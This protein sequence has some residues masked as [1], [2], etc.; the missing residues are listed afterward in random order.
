M[1]REDLN[2]IINAIE[3]VK[4]EINQNMNERFEEQDKG[5]DEKFKEQ[6]KRINEM[7]KKQEQK[8]A[9][10]FKDQD[11]KNQQK[12]DKQNDRISSLESKFEDFKVIVR[13]EI[14]NTI[15]DQMFIFEERY[16]RALTLAV[17][18]MNHK[19]SNEEAQNIRLDNLE[20]ESNLN[21]AAV[22]NHEKRISNIEDTVKKIV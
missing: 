11:R 21:S 7:F 16:G 18:G 1:S 4:V 12:F 2:Q 17:E 20:K 9:K 5:I 14:K 3:T 15:L 13:E 6:D 10:M 19:N 8:N 22:F